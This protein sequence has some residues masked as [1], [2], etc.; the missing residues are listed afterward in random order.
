MENKTF[1]IS[2]YL[3]TFIIILGITFTE[4]DKLNFF[5]IILIL[6]FIINTQLRYF[7]FRDISVP[8]FISIIFDFIFG[9]ILYKNYN[10]LLLP[11]FIIGIIDSF[12]LIENFS[13]YILGSLGL[14]IFLY[15]G[16]EL[17]LYELLSY[18]TAIITLGLIS[19][20]IKKEQNRTLKAEELYH[21]LRKSE[22][23]LIKTN[24]ELEAYADSIKELSIL[25]ERN[26]ISREIHDSVGHSLSTIIIQLGAIEKI[27]NDNGEAAS[28]M[29]SNLRDFTKNGLEEIRKALRELKPKE[30]KEYETLLAIEGLI[31]DF[32]KLTGI[33]VKLGFSKNKWQ[34]DE[35]TS[36]VLYRV[37]QEFLS[38]SARHGKATK[39]SIFMH[40][41]IS[42]LIVTMQDN[43]IGT[44]EITPGLGLT[45]ISER[46]G[47]LGGNLSY[48]SKEG[49]GFLLRVVLK[50]MY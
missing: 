38:N 26:R 42:D 21:R 44:N 14:L 33:D 5:A 2:R 50:S 12:F 8:V 6:L 41:S 25:K 47:E 10:G 46:V 9:Y 23:E 28:L 36:L 48:E 11:Y 45:S 37:V 32:S 40:F 22:D 4:I 16:N 20:I 18:I 27:A 15:A 24:H 29:A 19:S 7:L 34:L 17:P 39:I 31:K 49:K 13:K 43:G 1:L 3:T 35:E 30:F